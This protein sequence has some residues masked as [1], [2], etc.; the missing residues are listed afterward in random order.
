MK[1]LL[2]VATLLLSFPAY[3]QQPNCDARDKALAFLA[4]KYQEAPVAMGV[5]TT[6]GLIEVVTSK[7]GSTWTLLVT[8]PNGQSCLVAAGEAWRTVKAKIEGPEA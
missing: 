7:D 3:A 2:V 6:G 1:H 8:A 5:T 4:Q